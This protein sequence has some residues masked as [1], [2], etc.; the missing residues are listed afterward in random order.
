MTDDDRQALPPLPPVRQR[1]GIRP[2]LVVA[3]IAAGLVLCFG[4]LAAVSPTTTSR[5]GSDVAPTTPRK[6][7]GTSLLAVSALRALR[8]IEEPDTPPAN[9]LDAMTIP[10][11]SREISVSHR[12]T[13]TSYDRSM[14]FAVAAPQATLITFY[15]DELSSYGWKV[16][17][18]G[19]ATG[20]AGG[21]EVLAEKAGDDGWYWEEGAVISPTTFSGTSG[22]RES[23][24]F[25]IEVFEV[26]DAD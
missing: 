26:P 10:E 24:A 14:R 1:P 2:A 12:T 18:V 13:G 20:V 6:V 23:T 8:P 17:S 11:G 22:A 5:T 3:I 15:R 4:I 21:I 25:T 7:K 16:A 19:A 9:I